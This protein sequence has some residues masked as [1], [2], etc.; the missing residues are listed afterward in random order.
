LSVDVI[1]RGGKIVLVRVS[2]KFH[3]QSNQEIFLIAFLLQLRKTHSEKNANLS[4]CAV[5]D[6]SVV[7]GLG[8]FPQQAKNCICPTNALL[9]TSFIALVGILEKRRHSSI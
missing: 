1:F 8:K 5:T 4:E 7:R 9:A 6:F 3:K 2:N